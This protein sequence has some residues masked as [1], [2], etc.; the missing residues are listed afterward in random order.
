[1]VWSRVNVM[2]VSVS[3]V[4]TVSAIVT[5]RVNTTQNPTILIDRNP[6]NEIHE[7]RPDQFAYPDTKRISRQQP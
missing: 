3:V 4:D 5:V 2:L 7:T 1:M 6:R